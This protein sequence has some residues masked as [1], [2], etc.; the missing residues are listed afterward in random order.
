MA[1]LVEVEARVDSSPISLGVSPIIS[2]IRHCNC[3]VA[4]RS[5]QHLWVCV[6][7]TRQILLGALNELK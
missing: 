2:K 4:H 7:L 1:Q 6:R 5:S 3:N